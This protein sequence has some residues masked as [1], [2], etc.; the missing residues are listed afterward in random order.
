MYVSNFSKFILPNFQNVLVR[1]GKYIDEKMK[2]DGKRE[3]GAGMGGEGK[4]RMLLFNFHNVF[5]QTLKY[6]QKRV[7]Q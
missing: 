2:N 3:D 4:I 5:V 7:A 6:I 1:S